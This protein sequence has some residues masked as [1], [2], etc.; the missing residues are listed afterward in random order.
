MAQRD[1]NALEGELEQQSE[2]MR[3][4]VR[5]LVRDTAGAEDV[6]Q[7]AQLAAL[8]RRRAGESVERG[9]L[10]RVALNFARRQRRGE[11]T[12]RAHEQRGAR[13]ESG[14]AADEL[15]ARLDAQRAL[16]EELRA[17][18]EP[19]RSTLVRSYFDGWSA[20]RIAREAGCP[21]TTVRT[22]LERGL[23]LLRERLDR[24]HGGRRDWL[25]ALAPLAL[26]HLPPWL[27]APSAPFANLVQGVLLMKLGV[28]IVTAL[29]VVA[30]L[31]VGWLWRESEPEA[32]SRPAALAAPQTSET[33][34]DD[35]SLTTDRAAAGAPRSPSRADA[36]PETT[37]PAPATALPP[38]SVEARV[39]DRELRPIAGARATFD[40]GGAVLTDN[41]GHWKLVLPSAVLGW[42]TVRVDAPGY[43]VQ[44]LDFEPQAGAA[45]HLGD[46]VLERGASIAGRVQHVDG[47]PIG[48]ATVLATSPSVWDADAEA[49]RRCGPNDTAS[50]VST[51][52]AP[53]GSF[54]LEGVT[55]G[56]VRVWAQVRDMR[57]ALSEALVARAEERLEGVV[58]IVEPLA[59]EDEISGI[60]RAPNGEPVSG[61]G[62]RAMTSMNGSTNSMSHAVG[63]D[64]AFTFRVRQT[65]PHR[66]TASDPQRRWPEVRLENVEPGSRDVELRFEPPRHIAVRARA[67][68]GEPVERFSLV[69][70]AAAGH[71][72]LE[73]TPLANTEQ[74]VLRVRV[75][76]QEF[77][78]ECA[79]P[80]FALEQLGP[81]TPQNPPS[82]LEFELTPQPG[83]SGR[84]FAAG[85]PRSGA[86]VTLWRASRPDEGVEVSGFPS[87]RFPR[88]LDT[89]ESDADGTYFLRVVGD[90]PFFVR[91]EAEGFAA[92][93]RG[94]FE[95]QSVGRAELDLVLGS[96]GRIEGRVLVAQGRSEEGVIVAANRGDGFVRTTRTSTG[97]SFSFDRLSAGAW[98]IQRGRSEV[99]GDPFAN[100]AVAE[101]KTPTRVEFNCEVRE[102]A[103][104]A[105]TLDLR[106]DR[107]AQVNGR[108]TL[109][110]APAA[111]WVVSAWPGDRGSFSGELP[112]TALDE[113]GRFELALEEPGPARLMFAWGSDRERSGH[114]SYRGEFKPGANEWSMD[115]RA[116]P[117]RGR[118]ARP[119]NA[120]Y[121]LYLRVETEALQAWIPIV[122][123]A[124]GRFELPLAP[125]GRA[126]FLGAPIDGGQWGELEVLHETLL[127]ASSTP[128][129]ELR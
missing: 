35:H 40:D 42:N 105:F 13:D 73:R 60:V 45:K 53:D 124:E 23:E 59:R 54:L 21:A 103:T 12:R 83:L 9:W 70:R 104:T 3:R 75:P 31:G 113:H 95:V 107:P 102:G 38:T 94:P 92:D 61:I 98:S 100:W 82:S 6:V 4:L 29:A 128:F 77:V 55:P 1:S 127:S 115:L 19:Y 68:D 84:V 52:S 81:F 67:D 64:G 30:V 39:V 34:P 120:N 79:A 62:L 85:A 51:T 14:P 49:A 2:W 72:E 123:D 17:L 109:N 47:R 26:P 65:G 86:R 111:G 8:R 119:A 22:R 66:L 24:R 11:A 71:D 56:G 76:A 97:G 41:K 101:A 25:S 5:R 121:A 44:T 112:S 18:P 110:G 7:E 16:A 118:S 106:D 10:A 20:A 88:P 36:S 126:S 74:G 63:L 78:V 129:I 43:A 125:E 99:S 58:L 91:A 117:L 80:G 28:Q 46:I 87:L 89:T 33:A 122:T 15:A 90:D 93:D 57:Y 37:L 108:L 69:A 32:A 114:V 48:A 116:S 27:D 50:A 96:G